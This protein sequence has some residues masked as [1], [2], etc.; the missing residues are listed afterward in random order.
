[1]HRQ[2]SRT[3]PSGTH[4]ALSAIVLTTVILAAVDTPATAGSGGGISSQTP[5]TTNTAPSFGTGSTVRSV[6]ENTAAGRPIGSPVRATDPD[7]GDTL[8]YRLEGTDSDAFDLVPATGQLRTRAP[9]NH[10]AM[11]SHS[12]VIVAQ[13]S[14]GATARVQVTI[15][16]TDQPEPPLAPDAPIVGSVVGSDTSSARSLVV[17]W[18]APE[19]TGKP[20][21]ESYDVRFKSKKEPWWEYRPRDNPDTTARIER[22]MK[23]TVYEVKVRATND[24]GDGPW[25]ASGT[26]ITINDEALQKAWLAHFGRTVAGQVVN[27]V[28]ARLDGDGSAHVTAEGVNL[29]LPSGTREAPEQLAQVWP[30]HR[31]QDRGAAFG[32]TGMSDIGLALGSAFHLSSNPGPEGSH[33]LTAWGRYAS[34]SFQSADETLELDREVRTAVLGADAEWDRRLAGLALSFSD[35]EGEFE[36]GGRLAAE[37]GY[38]VGVSGGRGVLTPYT[39]LSLSNDDERTYRL[40]GRWNVGPAFNIN[41]EGDRR[42]HA[43]D[44]SPEHILMLRGTM[45]W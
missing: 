9:L 3:R 35:G 24:E 15:A 38:G 7:P 36:P 8:V 16:V 1:M 45:R 13:D 26:T 14:E 18:T 23:D 11:P 29:R 6:A 32:T 17:H 21:I 20:A 2:S 30:D 31:A 41:L 5:G 42:E 25:S 4:R 40:G 12:V 28:S 10:E 43:D 27:A 33:V 34:E 39:G 22:L 44:G 37:I 19:N